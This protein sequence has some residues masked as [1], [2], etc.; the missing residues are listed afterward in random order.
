MVGSYLV[1]NDEKCSPSGNIRV[2]GSGKV[3]IANGIKGGCFDIE[4][5]VKVVLGNQVGRRCGGFPDGL[6]TGR[7]ELRSMGRSG[8]QGKNGHEWFLLLL[9]LLLSSYHGSRIVASFLHKNGRFVYRTRHTTTQHQ[10]SIKLGGCRQVV[11]MGVNS[12]NPVLFLLLQDAA[13]C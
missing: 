11:E 1:G 9:L 3:G 13:L 5:V 12:T 6:S 8:R 10:D 2:A 4:V 7:H